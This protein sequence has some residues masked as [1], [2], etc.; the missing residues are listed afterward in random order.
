MNGEVVLN[1]I[2]RESSV[3]GWRDWDDEWPASTSENDPS[4]SWTDTEWASDNWDDSHH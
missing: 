3:N 4:P 2:L 1:S